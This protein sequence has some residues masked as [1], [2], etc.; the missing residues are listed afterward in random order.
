MVRHWGLFQNKGVRVPHMAK[1][2]SK[3]IVELYPSRKRLVACIK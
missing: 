3:C 1:F 2:L